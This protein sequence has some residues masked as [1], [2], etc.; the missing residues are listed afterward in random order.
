MIFL[1]GS[2]ALPLTNGFVGEL[3]ILLGIFIYHQGLAVAAGLTMILSAVYMLQMYQRSMLG[4]T[5][6]N[7][8]NI[9]DLSLKEAI[10]M[11]PL[12]FL[13]F[14]L[15]IFPQS[16]ISFAGPAINEILTL[17]HP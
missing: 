13:V 9:K 12:A 3:L 2:I 7:T 14:W 5:N 16:I 1:L 11:I 10:P 8:E 4:E 15:G 17:L 6:R